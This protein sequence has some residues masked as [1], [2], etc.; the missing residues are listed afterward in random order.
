VA[1][2]NILLV[3]SDQHRFDCLAGNGHPC[4]QTPCL[5]QVAREGVNFTHAFC[6]I[7][8]CMP[9]R[10]SM[11]TG[12]WPAQHLLI[13]N[14]D[15]DAPRGFRDDLPT[16]TRVMADAG[17][18]LGYVGKWHAHP[19]KEP[20]DVGFH[21]YVS[22]WQYARWREQQGLPPRPHEN[23]W[24]GEP[25]PHITPEQSP[26]AW[27]TDHVIRMLRARAEDGQPFFIRHDPPE[28][29]LPCRPCAPYSSMYPPDRIEPWGSF[30]DTFTDK[31]YAQRQ[32]LRTWGI[33]DWTWDDWAPLVSRYLAVVTE[34]DAQI[35]RLIAA[36][37]E[38]GLT[39]DTLFVY[40]SDHGDM[41]GSHRMIDKHFVMYD[42][43]VRVPLVARWPGRVPSGRTCEAFVSNSIDLAST[44][45]E[46]AGLA[47]P[48]SFR[49]ESLCAL[50]RDEATGTSRDD[51]FAMYH[52]NQFGLFSQRMVRNRRW[53]YV[54]NATAQDE[55]YDLAA[56]P[57]ELTN[58]ARDRS[59][60]TRLA[61]LRR[62]LVWWMEQT[63][64]RLLNQ[65]TRPQLLEGRKQ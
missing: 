60:A 26:L 18:W 20:T 56:D 23:R 13:A 45:L 50:L 27:R 12:C 32:Q 25:D 1:R 24:F 55:L 5:D 34:M 17:Y 48:E 15:S 46:V 64:D 22:G 19:E 6:P 58:L 2:P 11:L 42:D 54:W 53:K 33:E 62:R 41:C 3:Q 47:I 65:W 43:V 7:P 14:T 49:G 63:D 35:G 36:L 44:F 52:G 57:W 10:A 28:P 59:H 61:E 51:V 29:H 31:P 37:D 4:L 38:L 21:E 9:T 39:R 30:N 16:F 40:T 8:L